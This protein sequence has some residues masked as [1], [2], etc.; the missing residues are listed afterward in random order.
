M[1]ACEEPAKDPQATSRTTVTASAITR[2]AAIVLSLTAT[3]VGNAV[4]TT[5]IGSENTATSNA[6][7]LPSASSTNSSSLS[8]SDRIAIS[9]GLG[10]G[11]PSIVIA[12]L[13][14]CYPR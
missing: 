10:V 9:V 5:A 6:D 7:A 3:K 4:S 1:F 11:V 13:A 14:W 8:I 12:V 2:V